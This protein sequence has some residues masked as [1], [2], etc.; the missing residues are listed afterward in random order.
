MPPEGYITLQQASAKSFYYMAE[1]GLQHKVIVIGEM[2]GAADSEYALRE[3]Q[4]G[5]GEGDL[6]IS[7]VEKDSETN[8]ME[9]TIRRVKG[10]CGFVSSTTD[11]E[12]NPENETRNF[13]IYI[14]IDERK[15]KRTLS[16]IVDKYTKKSKLLTNEEILLFH[17][18]QRC[19]QTNV[20][21]E[22]PYIKY[23][24][25]KFPLTPIRV[26]RDRV[27]FC[28]L[29]ATIAVFHQFQRK[30]YVDEDESKWVVASISD[31]N[32]AL[33]LMDEILLETIYELPP[34]SREIYEE[35]KKMREEFV[36]EDKD[37]AGSLIDDDRKRLLFNTTYKKIGERKKIKMKGAD[38]RRWSK[39]LFEAGYFDYYETDSES[40]KGGRGK[41][42]KLIPIDKDFYA[43]FLPSPDELATHF[44]MFDESLYN[45]LTGEQRE[46][47]QMEVEL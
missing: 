39:P 5:I 34:K 25:D 1:T 22:I 36:E 11:V 9:T 40:G 24:L 21:V 31:Y 30:V 3:A 45:P 19:L 16:P 26:M 37:E 20:N 10:P 46:L 18:A 6:I 27:R 23:V 38:I 12:I 13:S 15:V 28:T 17:N 35:V 43:S 47:E 2:H 42:T 14:R 4:D 7:T 8:R 32:V 44:G 33:I 41:E 29:L